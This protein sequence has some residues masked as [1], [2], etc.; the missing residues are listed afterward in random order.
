M[1][2]LKIVQACFVKGQPVEAGDI[3]ENVENGVAAELLLSGRAKIFNGEKPKP[4]PAPEVAEEPKKKASKKV[5]KKAA[6]NLDAN[7]DSE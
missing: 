3:L 6:K 5:T 1:K 4:A 2:N 7:N